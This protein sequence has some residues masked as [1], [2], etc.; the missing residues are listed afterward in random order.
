MLNRQQDRHL[1][2]VFAA[3]ADP[4]RRAIVARLV[5]GPASVK[6]LAEPFPISLPAVMQ[7]LRVL[8]ECG[9]VRSDKH[10]RVRTCQIEPSTLR[11]AEAWLAEQRSGW[12]HQLDR[13]ELELRS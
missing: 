8:E 1:D 10:G 2:S 5:G 11:A 4:T 3:L 13:L 9:L 7:H 12:E 6:A